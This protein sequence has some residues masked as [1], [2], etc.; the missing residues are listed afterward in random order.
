MRDVMIHPVYLCFSRQEPRYE[1]G[2]IESPIET[3]L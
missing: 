3:K 1:C 2:T